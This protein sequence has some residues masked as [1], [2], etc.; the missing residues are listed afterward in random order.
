VLVTPDKG[1]KVL[2]DEEGKNSHTLALPEGKSRL[3]IVGKQ[4]AGSI[5]VFFND[6]GP[7]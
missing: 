7:N 3:K 6:P 5:S 1:V 2:S 4:A